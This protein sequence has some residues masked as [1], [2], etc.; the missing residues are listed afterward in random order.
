MNPFG[1]NH[2][3]ATIRASPIAALKRRPKSN[4][5]GLFRILA[6]T[7]GGQIVALIGMPILARLYTPSDFGFLAVVTS[8]TTIVGTVAALRFELAIPIAKSEHEAFSLATLGLLSSLSTLLVGSLSILIWGNWLSEALLGGRSAIWLWCI[9][10]IAAAIGIFTVLNQLA[11]RGRRFGEIGRRSF[12]QAAAVV[13]IQSST[14]AAGLRPGGLILGLGLG[15]AVGAATLARGARLHASEARPSR[16]Y[17]SLRR[18]ARS[19]RRFPLLLAPAGLINIIGLQAPIL[20]FAQFYGPDVAGWLGLTQR[21]IALP[22]AL[23]GTA[24]AQVFLAE[25]SHKYRSNPADCHKMFIRASRKLALFGGIAA[26]GLA[27]GGPWM[28]T[29]AFGRE[30]SPSG[31]YAQALALSLAAQ[32]VAAP[33]SQTLIVFGK[34]A[35]QLYWDASRLVLVVGLV[36]LAAR[37]EAS[38]ICAVWVMGAASAAAYIASWCLSYRSTNRA[39]REASER[40][41]LSDPDIRKESHSLPS[42]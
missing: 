9:P 29:L 3:K 18:V 34:V 30:W 32:F 42:A 27:F 39:H 13:I 22:I 26:L 23:I 21:V 12:V 16:G 2:L 28:F 37:L 17:A 31:V 40:G 33:L 41:R 35:A 20:V 5:G 14:G 25:L 24:V 15:Q 38:P 36:S 19:Y 6:G 4:T 10:T 1:L 11:I 8:I 7:A